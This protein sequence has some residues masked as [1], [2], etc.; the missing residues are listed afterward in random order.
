MHI[1]VPAET[2][3][4]EA[5]VTA[6]PETV[7]KLVTQGHRVSVQ[8]GAGLPTKLRS[9]ID[10]VYRR[11]LRTGGPEFEGRRGDNCPLTAVDQVVMKHGVHIVGHTNLASMVAADASALYARNLLDFLKLILTRKARSPS[12]SRTTSSRPRFSTATDKSRGPPPEP[13]RRRTWTSS[14]TR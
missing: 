11:R 8:S 3:A 1:G 4:N 5:R 13:T 7:K 2:R 10:D 9:Y 12:T 14:I 6:T